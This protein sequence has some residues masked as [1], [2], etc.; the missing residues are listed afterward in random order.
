MSRQPARRQPPEQSSARAAVA[1]TATR[2]SRGVSPGV[3]V[4]ATRCSRGVSS[5]GGGA[6]AAGA[7]RSIDTAALVRGRVGEKT[8]EASDQQREPIRS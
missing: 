2:G 6:A 1:A 8:D 5:D 7:A 4:T 3:A